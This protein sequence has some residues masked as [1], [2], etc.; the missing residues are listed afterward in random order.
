MAQ[1]SPCL[2]SSHFTSESRG[3]RYARCGYVPLGPDVAM[4]NKGMLLDRARRHLNGVYYTVICYITE[5][6]AGFWVPCTWAC[7]NLA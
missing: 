2:S 4:T 6:E 5:V 1:P 3:L 7:H